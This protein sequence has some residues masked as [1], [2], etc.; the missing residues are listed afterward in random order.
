MADD[1]LRLSTSIVDRG[2]KR[3]VDDLVRALI[4]LRNQQALQ[5]PALRQAS[6]AANEHAQALRQQAQAA[7]E[8]VR[9]MQAAAAATRQS[10]QDQVTEAQRV[11][12][13]ASAASRE[14]LVAE[15]SLQ[16]GLQLAARDRVASARNALQAE[17]QS[18]REAVAA[19][20]EA[21]RA[22]IESERRVFQAQIESQ[23]AGIY[24][25]RERIKRIREDNK[26]E[27]RLARERIRVAKE[28][29]RQAETKRAGAVGAQVPIA[30]RNLNARIAE[31]EQL[32]IKEKEA[33]ADRQKALATEKTILADKQRTH[34]ATLQQAR[35]AL[36]Q[37]R[38][39]GQEEIR[40]AKESAR[41]VVEAAREK[42]R[43]RLE[44]LRS[45]GRLSRDAVANARA[46]LSAVK[47]R[48]RD[49][50]DAARVIVRSNNDAARSA[51]RS[52]QEQE[53]AHRRA[54]NAAQQAAR[55]QAVA[56]RQATGAL[57]AQA[58]AI[59]G[60]QRGFD[61]LQRTIIR[62]VAAYAGFRAIR[63]FIAAG[64]RFNEIIES[65]R[66]GI[67]A[68]ITA[69]A[70]VIDAQGR[71]ITGVRALA[72]AQ[73]LA[74]DQVNK[75]RVAGIQTVATTEEL[76][77]TFQEAV[78]AG[79][80]VGLTLDQIRQFSVSVAQ[81]ASAI[82]LPM[83]QLQQ[84]TRSILQGTIDRN[85]RIAK[86][87]QLTNAEVNLAKQQNRLFE[88]LN[89]KFKAFNI[90]GVESVKTFHALRSNISDAFS[91]FAGAATESL[92]VRLR[93]AGQ[94][95]LASIFDF[96][97]A[98]IQNSFRGL[99]DGLKTIFDQIGQTLAS[100]I[101]GAVDRA[102]ALSEWMARNREEVKKT[103][104]AVSTMVRDFFRMVEAIGQA[105]L[106]MGRLTGETNAV[107]GLARILSSI[108]DTIRENVVLIAVAL[109]SAALFTTLKNLVAVF[110]AIRG[111]AGLL[112]AG[113]G[114]AAVAAGG[115]AAGAAPIAATILGLT[116][117]YLALRTVVKA[118]TG[119]QKKLAQETAR[120]TSV[121]QDQKRS[122]SALIEE[123]V[124]TSRLLQ[125]RTITE[126]DREILTA[127][128]ARTTEELKKIDQSYATAVAEGT[129]D[130][131][132]RAAALVVL[133][134]K[135]LAASAV[136]AHAA[137]LRKAALQRELADAEERARPVSVK[138]LSG[139]IRTTVD[140]R[141]RAKV[142]ELREAFNNAAAAVELT[143]EQVKILEAGLQ[144]MQTDPP[145]IR[146][147]KPAGDDTGGSAEERR[148][149][150]AQAD[151]ELRKAQIDAQR[152][153]FDRQFATRLITAE[154]HLK[155]LML[156]DLAE[157]KAEQIF[158]A[159]QR[160][161]ADRKLRA[162]Q[163]GLG[164]AK[165]SQAKKAADERIKAAEDEVASFDAQNKRL[166]NLRL[167]KIAEYDAKVAES[168]EQRAAR[169]LEIEQRFLQAQGKA[170]EAATLEVQRKN[171]RALREAAQE[172]G[173][174][175]VQARV[176]KVAP[177]DL[178]GMR[179]TL[180][181]LQSE[182]DKTPVLAKLIVAVDAESRREQLEA[183]EGEVRRIQQAVT[184]EVQ[185][186]QASFS[187]LGKLST[188][189]KQDQAT[190]IEAVN[191]RAT[192]ATMEL[193]HQLELMLATAE[194]PVELAWIQ[195]LI[196]QLDAMRERA[197]AVNLELQRLEQ[198]ARESL[199]S[200]L[201]TFFQEIGSGSKNAG[202][203]FKAMVK[204]IIDDMRRLV[205]EMTAR[206][207]VKALFGA[208][209][210]AATGAAT[211]GGQS[212]GNTTPSGGRAMG[213]PARPAHGRLRGG[214]AGKDS[215]P[216]LAMAD[217]WF[218]RREAVKHYGDDFLNMINS[219]QLPRIMPRKPMRFAE[220]GRVSGSDVGARPPVQ[221]T[222]EHVIGL[223][224]NGALTWMT[225]PRGR[226]IV[227]GH[228]STMPRFV[229]G[230]GKTLK[231]PGWR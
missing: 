18:Q 170:Y 29:H 231:R 206:S 110:A 175:T 24:F 172:F 63:G 189:Q 229:T 12:K 86:S 129:G 166:A 100:A 5:A 75:L 85:S 109:G 30:D 202:Q 87:L 113:G 174:K 201:A 106:G 91:V 31:L 94:A 7:L 26:E 199:E 115:A 99:L 205:A 105:V 28:A 59:P 122:A 95:A 93:D 143:S 153:V 101:R 181:E 71:Q 22:R 57:V 40:V 77:T 162:A 198:G 133:Q 3:L 121:L 196:S 90:A 215:I 163:A 8:N 49:N 70:D 157:I 146:A 147:Q 155:G 132:D 32:R 42:L 120:T 159:A 36:A 211:S 204:G 220:G 80:S 186:I 228:L 168:A 225:G 37:L 79:L 152:A 39:N 195:R 123:Y 177:G 46:E 51:V 193:R 184:A 62:L 19:V 97:T 148:I 164:K 149:K 15:Q 82:H 223:D 116:G 216:I 222:V 81:A 27:L 88:L 221:Q 119:D 23:R 160:E 25:Q 55:R 61:G 6:A 69:Q 68:L 107:I 103:A 83:N 126:S 98:E 217:E 180:R 183:I 125:D 167:T 218:I 190:Q 154:E 127:R 209:A 104:A 208:A 2:A 74:A 187:R 192:D 43:A 96:K 9:A 114:I 48:G 150:Q 21:A 92:F 89:E 142:E 54:A 214:T 130:I 138:M 230:L 11:A 78:G 14:R 219:M 53:R 16:R 65:S 112:S 212:A 200:G 207:I 224:Q 50:V 179:Q 4:G 76:I 102:Q 210:G 13:A 47:K 140:P 182:V 145:T 134:Q 151:F 173:T 17:V 158:L 35:E 128:L 33:L 56:L 111:A 161:E 44:E 52:S 117:V 213:G 197:I 137:R 227:K 203:A 136:D 72:A 131:K 10:G 156:L 20:R 144:R 1:D 38:R 191:R 194:T 66:L 60:L 118:V 139:D 67:A 34:T 165:G 124:S 169:V 171:E 64:L 84:E 226:D 141:A 108:F 135:A 185:A 45:Q 58:R 41:G 73:G 188:A 178:E 176:A